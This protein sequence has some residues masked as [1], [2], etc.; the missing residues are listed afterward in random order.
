M[1]TVRRSLR[2][3]VGSVFSG[4]FF[5]PLTECL[6]FP[7]PKKGK[8]ECRGWDRGVGWRKQR[9]RDASWEV[10]R[11]E[12]S[13]LRIRKHVLTCPLG[14]TWGF[15]SYVTCAC[16]HAKCFSHVDCLQ[17]RGLQPARVLY[18]WDSPGKNTGV[19]SMNTGASMLSSRGSF[20]SLLH[21]VKLWQISQFY[22]CR[23]Y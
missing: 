6:E 20:N 15:A 2:C 7:D 3:P 22:R 18:P 12:N 21:P 11:F 14:Q 8:E 19:G 4:S 13:M 1:S 23:S 5:H 16:V 9:I 17:P 10:I